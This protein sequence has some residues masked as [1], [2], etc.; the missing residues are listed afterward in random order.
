MWFQFQFAQEQRE[1]N[2][3]STCCQVLQLGLEW[4]EQNWLD[5]LTV[6]K[7]TTGP[8]RRDYSYLITCLGRRPQIVLQHQAPAAEGPWCVRKA[9]PY[10]S[11]PL[12]KRS[13][14]THMCMSAANEARKIAL[15]DEIDSGNCKRFPSHPGY[16]LS[17][18]DTG[19]VT[20]YYLI[21]VGNMSDGK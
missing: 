3:E 16:W 7:R 10:E 12:W 17:H 11:C 8:H 9:C 2:A 21:L 14:F 4:Q 5:E 1:K 6:P 20:S 18:K 19:N 15:M 13:V